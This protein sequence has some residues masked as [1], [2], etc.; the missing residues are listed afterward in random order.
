MVSLASQ[1]NTDAL[2]T[3]QLLLLP[4]MSPRGS[5]TPSNRLLRT[6][7]GLLYSLCTV[8]ICSTPLPPPTPF[9]GRTV[10]LNRLI[11]WIILFSNSRQTVQFLY[12][13]WFP[14]ENYGSRLTS[15][16]FECTSHWSP[17][18]CV[19]TRTHKTYKE[20]CFPLNCICL[21]SKDSPML[22]P[23]SCFPCYSYSPMWLR[24]LQSLHFRHCVQLSTLWLCLLRS[25]H[26]LCTKFRL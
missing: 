23:T 8:Y 18:A 1:Y 25:L 2:R 7:V 14:V 15:S 3:R 26:I 17:Q 9:A 6:W 10:L 12:N 4:I 22:I 16:N 24:S 21:I 19:H 5:Y 13:I 20:E 11:A